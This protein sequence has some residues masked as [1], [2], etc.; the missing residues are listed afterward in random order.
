[1]L[2]RFW[3]GIRIIV[4]DV[5]ERPI[6]PQHDPRTIA[7]SS[8]SQCKHMTISPRLFLASKSPRRRD[9]LDQIG[10]AYQTLDIDVVE[11][12]AAGEVALDYVRR[13]ARDK[14]RAGL[15]KV[16][17][18]AGALVLG[19]D[20]EVVLDGRIF[21]K[22]VGVEDASEML[23]ALSGRSH[24][25][26]SAVTLLSESDEQ[27]VVSFSTVRFAPMTVQEVESYVL[28]GECMGKAGAYAIQGHA[29]R[30]IERIEG[31]YWGIMGLPLFETAGL[32]RRCGL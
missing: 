6:R 2:I 15:L 21:G 16:A 20:T 17:D 23:R 22:P 25:V 24:D 7:A 14:A 30:F 11:Q 32:L 29:A 31:S 12:V 3:M 4:L 5:Q 9:L 19:A 10:V 13:V 8:V 28:T 18:V 27:S 1:V 26:I